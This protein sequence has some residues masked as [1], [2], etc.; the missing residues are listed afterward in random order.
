MKKSNIKN[1]IVEKGGLMIEALAMLGLIAVVTPT[2][3]KKSAE[4]V[5]EVE[6]INTADTVRS[7]MGATEA[8]MAANYRKLMEEMTADKSGEGETGGEGGEGETPD[9]S[10]GDDES[11][12]KVEWGDIKAYL[13][14]GFTEDHDL[15]D[16]EFPKIAIV[17]QGSNLTAFALFPAKKDGGLG[18]ERT[19]R[20]ASLIGSNGGFT[21]T[22]K[23]A[24]G[25]GGVWNL[26]AAK[27]SE[28]FDSEDVKELSLVTASSN[29]INSISGAG[30]VENTKYLQRTKENDG[31]LWRN[32]MRTDLY[33]GGIE[34]DS[35]A[36]PDDRNDE[37]HSILNINSLLVGAETYDGIEEA[38]NGLYI[39]PEGDNPNAYIGGTLTAARDQLFADEDKMGYGRSVTGDGD[40]ASVSYKYEVDK[41]GNVTSVG[42]VDM[43]QGLAGENGTGHVYLGSLN[44]GNRNVNGEDASYFVQ[45]DATEDGASLSL[46]S[47]D[48]FK[49]TTDDDDSI[50]SDV[51]NVSGTHVMIENTGFK[52]ADN[53]ENKDSLG[54]DISPSYG[55]EQTFPVVVGSNMMVKGVMSAGQLDAQHLRTA[56][57]STGSANID[58]D[59][60]W[61]T[62]DKDG[63]IIRDIDSTSGS[64][65]NIT[66]D[67]VY[68]EIN[69]HGLLMRTGTEDEDASIH[70][71]KYIE[72]NS[73]LGSEI[74]A[75]ASEVTI[76]TND[77]T[78]GKVTVRNGNVGMQIQ[79][80]DMTIGSPT[81]DDILVR[82][83]SVN[84]DPYRVVFG[85]GGDVDIVGSNFKVIDESEK[86][87]LTVRGNAN[88]ERDGYNDFISHDARYNIATHG[89][90]LFSSMSRSHDASDIDAATEDDTVHFMAVGPY[91]SKA[92]VN[93]VEATGVGDGKNDEEQVLF[94]D[95]S[96]RDRNAYVD[97]SGY[98]TENLE[99]VSDSKD[100]SVESHTV[101]AGTV[102]VRKGMVEVVPNSD[103]I[104]IDEEG[105]IYTNMGATEG[106]GIIRG[107]RFVANNI[108]IKGELE[109][110]PA[111]FDSE[112]YTSYNG[113]NQQR[114]DTYMV[115]PAYT[116]VMKD[117]KLTTRGGA[118]LSDILP[119]FITKGIYLASNTYDDALSKMQFILQKDKFEIDAKEMGVPEGHINNDTGGLL[120]KNSSADDDSR[121][122]YNSWASPYSG[123]VPAPQCPPGYARVITINPFRLQMAE[124]GQLLLSDSFGDTDN[125]GYYVDT[126]NMRTTLKRASY[127]SNS[128]P[129]HNS[130]KEELENELMEK[131]PY[132]RT[133]ELDVKDNASANIEISSAGGFV[134]G[135]ESVRGSGN[136]K[137]NGIENVDITAVGGTVSRGYEWEDRDDNSSY[138]G[139]SEFHTPN[140]LSVNA[141]GMLPLVFQQSTWLHTE[142]VPV[143]S[144]NDEKDGTYI[145]YNPKDKYVRGWA[146]LQGFL[147][148]QSDYSNFA[149]DENIVDKAE[150]K[151][152]GV[153]GEEKYVLWNL[154]PVLKNSLGSYVNTY[155]YF[156]RYNMFKNFQN[157]GVGHIDR[158]NVLEEVGISYEKGMM[159]TEYD[160]ERQQYYQQ[161]NDPTMKYNEV[162]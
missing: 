39:N 138:V 102:Y 51:D 118:R 6:D 30:A 156:D 78:D 155:C 113:G 116:S 147:Y 8:Y 33:M 131:T 27:V 159:G 13:P 18:Q 154:F 55:N 126:L 42:N 132:I 77:D 1:T 157:G 34:S 90:V 31:E 84:N 110:V 66:T 96:S 93:I 88:T 94:V 37:L 100:A 89:N 87:I 125:A 44:N 106:S 40:D 127:R 114:Y 28:I 143:V 117:I 122:S 62:V 12:K 73:E 83:G 14:Y 67:G 2:M 103:D 144:W 108:N 32:A 158:Y 119:D 85:Q 53:K 151:N 128:T 162:W 92:G 25:I 72:G 79:G 160:A 74:Y 140:V 47:P 38:A 22:D 104:D 142:A 15:Y 91:D 56:T 70:M 136:I 41:Y 35:D 60:K 21:R 20:I 134:A 137:V 130:A 75:Q 101:K 97:S 3:Y 149:C 43:A 68:G 107:S 45:G 4:R 121:K 109:T 146:V 80:Q 145:G 95:L 61:L 129:G 23:S 54:N 10:V 76:E 153:K 112:V 36:D 29:V 99:L 5:L 148:H 133:L 48:I 57:F 71:A 150:C 64:D 135:T 65:D 141:G 59:F 63:I 11:F 16:Y 81:D 50:E 49:M 152:Y 115:N 24:H 46:L 139:S 123:L 98:D 26:D 86:N 19:S 17:R 124:A 120:E 58:D 105:K 111:L 69:K 52:G 82:N 7:Y 161:L 9:P